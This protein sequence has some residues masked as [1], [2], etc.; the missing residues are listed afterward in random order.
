MKRNDDDI[1]LGA[2]LKEQGH[3]AS[4]NPWFTPRVLNRLPQRE[5][6]VMGVWLAICAV[7]SVICAVC[8]F[9]LF[10]TLNFAVFTVRDMVDVIIMSIV[11]L[12][13]LWQSL[14]V[15]IKRE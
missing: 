8:W 10:D 14:S 9:R 12:I 4:E 13:L 11:T 5:K 3:Q 2:L 7:A 1:K 6:R 15:T